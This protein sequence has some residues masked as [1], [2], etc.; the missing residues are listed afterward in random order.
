MELSAAPDLPVVIGLP[1]L[2]LI[3][4]AALVVG[5][6]VAMRRMGRP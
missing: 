5:V 6:Y 2:L 1:F 3:A 4:S